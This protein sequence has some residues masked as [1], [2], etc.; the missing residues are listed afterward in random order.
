MKALVIGNSQSV[1]VRDFFENMANAK[2]PVYLPRTYE[3]DVLSW[4]EGR[5]IP[6]EKVKEI[7]VKIPRWLQK[8]PKL[9]GI[10]KM[11]KFVWTMSRLGSYDICHIH[12]VGIEALL[13]VKL[14]RKKSKRLIV[15][16]WGSDF[17]RTDK[18]FKKMQERV[19]DRA[20]YIT[21]STNEMLESFND[22]YRDRY[23]EKLRVCTFG[24]APLDFLK[25][26]T[27]SQ[28]DCK[29][30]FGIPKDA[31]SVCV[32]YNAGPWHR[33]KEIIKSIASSRLLKE[34]KTN[35][36]LILPM[37]YGGHSKY[38][39][40]VERELF[41]MKNVVITRFLSPSESAML[42]K[43]TDIF[44]NVQTTDVLS[45]S[46]LEHIYAGSV[47]ITGD[48]LPYKALEDMGIDVYKVSKP[49]DVGGALWYMLSNFESWRGRN[50]ASKE[51][52]YEFA[53]WENNIKSWV[54]LWR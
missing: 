36:F 21:F 28:E 14:A 29:E 26:G 49:D 22:Y 42:R 17:L 6:N 52:V 43:A 2:F 20:D 11:A 19:Y 3:I 18:V 40:E 38:I 34:S 51:N 50:H 39:R 27:A 41:G 32:G 25:N 30:H 48:W 13:L 15:S 33:H 23:V 31:I 47:V 5:L 7:A 35:L 1:F 4:N 16:V 24:L 45:G 9:R 44:I 46:M 37:T 12:F 10:F 53:S 54:R 8:I